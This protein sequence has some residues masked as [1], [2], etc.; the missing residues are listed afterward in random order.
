MNLPS[1]YDLEGDPEEWETAV[2][3][4][5]LLQLSRV[6]RTPLLELLGE[7][8]TAVHGPLSFPE[9]ANFIR[10]EIAGGR[11]KEDRIGW[12]LSEFWEKPTIAMEYPITFLKI[13]GNDV[14]FDWRRPLLSYQENSE[15][16]AGI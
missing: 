10:R 13:L 4:G 12:D 15:Q 2:E 8:N 6:L 7:S 1:Y 11:V 14:G 9:L 3:F 16:A 5:Q